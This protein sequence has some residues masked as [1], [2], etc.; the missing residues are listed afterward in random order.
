[1]K[2][3][4]DQVFFTLYFRGI[5]KRVHEESQK[6]GGKKIPSRW[7]GTDNL[8]RTARGCFR[9]FHH[10][11]WR[12][13]ILPYQRWAASPMGGSQEGWCC[14]SSPLWLSGRVS[15]YFIH[16]L[17]FLPYSTQLLINV[18]MLKI[19][20]I[21]TFIRKFNTLL[22]I[23][24]LERYC[25]SG[26]FNTYEQFKYHAQLSWGRQKI[27]QCWCQVSWIWWFPDIFL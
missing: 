21:F 24:E 25:M 2:I 10:A 19:A 1:M 27:L 14:S 12:N 20:G 8:L 4:E 7:M 22:W 26:N 13:T 9:C 11:G 17:N 23:N 6:P 16:L 18:N 3:G 5:H 15:K